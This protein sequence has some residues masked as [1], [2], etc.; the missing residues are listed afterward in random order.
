MHFFGKSISKAFYPSKSLLNYVP[1]ALSYPMYLVLYVLSCFKCHGPY[2]ILWQSFLLSCMLSCH[3]SLVIYV[4]SCA[5]ASYLM[6]GCTSRALRVRVFYLTLAICALIPY[7]LLWLTC[8][9]PYV[10]LSFTCLISKVFLCPLLLTH[11]WFL[12]LNIL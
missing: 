9:A 10:H 3:T 8:L 4:F 5:R 12:M 6:C 7:V 1:Y 11:L 2:V